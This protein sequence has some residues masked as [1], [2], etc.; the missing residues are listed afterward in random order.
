MSVVTIYNWHNITYLL[1]FALCQSKLHQVEVAVGLET[2]TSE[3][4]NELIYSVRKGGRIGII[5]D[6]IGY[7]KCV[8]IY[9]LVQH[10]FGFTVHRIECIYTVLNCEKE[11]LISI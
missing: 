7:T 11:F 2:D 4:L 3:I 5:G 10:D 9:F 1:F 8:I 6:Y